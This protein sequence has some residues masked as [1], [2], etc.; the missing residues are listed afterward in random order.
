MLPAMRYNLDE[1][2]T[3]LTVMELG[4]VTAAAARLNVAKSVVSKRLADFESSVGAALFLRSA[5]RIKATETAVRLAERLRPALAALTGAV[6]STAWDMDGSVPLTG[7]L[8]LAAPMTFGTMYLSPIVGRFAASHPELNL[9][10]DYDDR[11][12]DLAREGFDLA[13]RIGEARDGALKRR[14]LCDDHQVV[15][16]SPDYLARHGTPQTL[17]DLRRHQV[18]SYSH[19]PDAQLW[20]FRQGGRIVSPQVG[21][22]LALNNGEAMGG[23]AIAGLGLAILPSF[24]VSRALADGRLV[25]IPLDAETREL[26]I[27][28]VWPPLDPMPAKVRALLDHLVAEL[29]DGLPWQSGVSEPA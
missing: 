16:A 1:V 19:M 5:G 27:V 11:M 12:H 20:Q 29:K 28:A 7:T 23:M 6:E 3:F 24:I 22:R 13:I 10:I 14:K 9:R 17:N 26:P 15:C 18:I 21:G 8:A 4:A 2:E 25:E